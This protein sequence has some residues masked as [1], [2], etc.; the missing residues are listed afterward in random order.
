[1]AKK[2]I[3]PFQQG[4]Y[5]NQC[6]FY[7]VGNV[8]SLLFPDIRK[9]PLFETIWDFYIETYGDA[10]GA[11]YGIY[12]DR[13]NKIL[14]HVID[15]FELPCNVHRPWWSKKARS[16]DEFIDKLRNVLNPPNSAIIFGYEH[17]IEG[18]RGFYSHWS[19]IKKI[20]E[21]SLLLFDSDGENARIPIQ[22]CLLWDDPH[23]KGRPYKLSSTDTFI[24]SKT[25]E[26]DM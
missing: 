24:V 12:R 18:N 9:T 26:E 11:L 25:N 21:K 13:L 1:M 17:G 19:I 8:I 5:S 20:T 23:S 3:R 16:I 4:D 22:R 6:G 14:C 10:S 7:A 15:E 2:A